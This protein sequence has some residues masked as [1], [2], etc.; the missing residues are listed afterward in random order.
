MAQDSVKMFW[1]MVSLEARTQSG[2]TTRMFNCQFLASTAMEAQLK[3]IRFVQ[4]EGLDLV[5][6]KVTLNK[7]AHPDAR[8]IDVMPPTEAER[9]AL[10]VLPAPEPKSTKKAPV[11]LLRHFVRVPIL[12]GA[13]KPYTYK[14]SA[15]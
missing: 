1:W 12:I 10:A 15:A 5:S 7:E 4:S 3:G 6:S 9:K 13:I 8:G 2:T 11:D 14:E